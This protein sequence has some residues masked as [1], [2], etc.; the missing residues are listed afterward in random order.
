MN[1]PL[2]GKTAVVTG[3]ARGI[4][5]AAAIA[6]A[7]EGA[8]IVA[9]DLD[10]LDELSEILGQRTDNSLVC[11]CNVADE[12]AVT[13]FI[14]AGRKQYGSI[15]ILV[16]NA[17]V[18]LEKPLVDTSVREFDRVFDV[19]VKGAFLVGRA[20]IATM[21]VDGIKGRVINIASELGFLGRE[22]FS[23]YCATK[24]AIISMTRSWAREFAPDILINAIA[25]GPVD[26]A[27][28][29]LEHLSPEWAEKELNTPLK[30]IGRP[31]EIA[32]AIVFLSGHRSTF[33]T[34]QTLGINGGAAMY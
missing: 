23:V 17:G 9:C 15:D 6:L 31:E 32:H 26:T 34:G 19:N 5:R 2:S 8:N 18:I 7:D 16:N 29:G 22:R 20:T 21:Q 10:G 4:G 24:G 1:R 27:M 25:P 33:V 13:E 12:A 28:V 30:R 3:A 14:A 11:A